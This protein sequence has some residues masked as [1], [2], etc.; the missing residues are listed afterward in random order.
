M[1]GRNKPCLNSPSVI[2]FTSK[3][4]FFNNIPFGKQI[5]LSHLGLRLFGILAVSVFMKYIKRSFS[6]FFESSKISCFSGVYSLCCKQALSQSN[7]FKT[8][9]LKKQ[10]NPC[11][12]FRYVNCKTNN[13]IFVFNIEVHLQGVKRLSKF[14][15]WFL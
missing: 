8:I 14:L 5:K 1:S 3:V 12:S 7:E 2:L 6:E 9:Y 10:N 4:L 13:M 11:A 15:S